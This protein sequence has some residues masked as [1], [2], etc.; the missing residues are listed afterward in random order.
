[1]PLAMIVASFAGYLVAG[2]ALKPVERMR[3]R[4]AVIT[5]VDLSERLPVP[6][7]DDEL[8]RLGRTLN[9]MLDRL[10]ETVQRERRLVSDAS[11]ELRT[12]LAIL[13]AELEVALGRPQDAD[14]LRTVVSSAL[15]EV[16]R[17]SRLSEDLLVL[18]RVDQGRL[19]LRLEPLDVQDVVEAAVGRHRAAARE[20]GRELV[21]RVAIDGGA[22]V[23]ADADRVAQMLD[24]LIVNALRWGSGRIDVEADTAAGPA[25]AISVRDTGE[26]F[27]ESF[28]ERAFER[29]SQADAARVGA[30]SGLGLSIVAALAQAQGGTAT[31]GA[32][33]GGGAIVTFTLPHA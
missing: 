24:N 21:T 20:A 8:E 6:R 14:Q 31:A 4:A 17:L 23:L 3:R 5:E 16:R 18:A 9:A 13:R 15:E 1:V 12:P 28:A 26:G 7:T 30:H 27:P 19:P 29:F 32:A 11:H 10:D 25:V 33:I 2:A 22:V